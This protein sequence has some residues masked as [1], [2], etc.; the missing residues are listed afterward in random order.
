MKIS[1]A[2]VKR[3]TELGLDAKHLDAS[4]RDENV[5]KSFVIE[6]MVAGVLKSDEVA[7]LSAQEVENAAGEVIRKAIADATAGQDARFE[8]LVSGQKALSDALAGFIRAS[9]VAA[10]GE[11]KAVSDIGAAAKLMG[12]IGNDGASTLAGEQV[13]AKCVS[14]MFSKSCSALDWSM[15][16]NEYVAKNKRGPVMSPSGDGHRVL[17]T[18]SELDQAVSGGW[19]KKMIN[20]AYKRQGV[21]VPPAFKMT[22]FDNR[23]VEYTVN[24]CKFIGPV[25]HEGEESD[26]A[27][28]WFSGTKANSDMWKKALLDDVTSGGL[29]AVPIEFDNAIITQ[30]VLTGEFLPFINV[31]TTS[32]RRIEGASIGQPTF[33]NTAEG[34]A[35]SP[36]NTASFVAAFDTTIFP[37]VGA[38][39]IGLDFMDDSPVNMGAIISDRYAASFANRLDQLIA[40]GSG[41]NEMLGLM[42][43]SGLASVTSANGGTGPITV[44]DLEGLLFGVPKA[45]RQE[46][47]RTQSVFVSNDVTYRRI[48]SIQVGASDQRRVYGMEHEN[49]MT[50]DHPHRISET[51]ANTRAGFF[52]L[53]RYRA[54]RRQGYT[55]R[56]ETA[57]KTLTMANQQLIYVRA[58]FGGQLEL[59]AAGSRSTNFQT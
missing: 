20:N 4:Q 21:A 28:H 53:N 18:Q 40:E 5:V 27:K 7:N 13:R 58:R 36:F 55:V 37:I 33:S 11:T 19:F 41:T 54:Y 2:L 23:L 35:V 49:Y 43:T 57:G 10:P 22:E 6:K 30:A 24:N 9:T 1:T 26:N 48:R 32:R 38:M 12:S 52:C 3:C 51:T 15:S 47:G 46:A 8:A 39:E 16:G 59:G 56:I 50:H 42:N 29:E 31:Q 45:Y 34:T 25:G 17:N 44:S 14:E